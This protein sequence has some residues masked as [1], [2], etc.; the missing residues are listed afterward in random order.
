MSWLQGFGEFLWLSFLLLSPML[1]LGLFLSGLFHVFISREAV[2]RW[3]RDESLNSVSTSALIGVP[4]PLCSCS[5]VPVVA[6]MRRKGAS[7]SACI[8]F[9][10]TAP[11]TGADS[12]LV[13]NAFFGWIPAIF[14][15]FVSYVTAVV[16]G[17]VCIGLIREDQPAPTTTEAHEHEHEHGEDHSCGHDHEHDAHEKLVP[18]ED[19]CYIPLPALKDLAIERMRELGTTVAS[20]R[21]ISWLK[22]AFYLERLDREA[23]ER[24]QTP[25][26]SSAASKYPH[27]PNFKTIV[28]HIFRY[29]FVE[30]AD[31][32]LFALLVGIALG[33]V[34]YLA[35]PTD[36]LDNEYA[37]WFSYPIMVIVG[38][39]LYICASAS[40]P[41]AA[42]LVAKGFSPGAALIFLMTGPA[43]NTGTVAIIVSQF[44]AKF[45]TIYVSSVIVVTVVIG[46]LLDVVLLASGFEIVVNL[47]KSEST[48]IAF[49]QIVCAAILF[50]LIVW[51]FRAGALKSGWDDLWLNVRPVFEPVGRGLKRLAGGRDLLHALSFRAP[52]VWIFLFAFALI[53][54]SSGLTT[55]PPGH[56]GYGRIFGAV[57]WQD[58]QP[59]LHYLGPPPMV[60]VD[61]WPIKQVK[62]VSIA[63]DTE[64]VTGDLNLVRLD[65]ALQYRV[66][67][68][69]VYHYRM[70]NAAHILAD[71]AREALRVFVGARSLESLLNIERAKLESY[72]LQYLKESKQSEL[73]DSIDM[74]KASLLSIGPTGE[75]IKA[76]REV[77]SAQEDR[78]RIIVNGQRLLVT[79]TP[80]AHGN[81]Q[82]ELKVAEGQAF[83]TVTKAR[84]EADALKR[85]SN[86][87][88]GSRDVLEYMLWREK[89]ETA[90][91][92]RSK[93]IVPNA[94]SLKK[95]AL[96]KA[97]PGTNAQSSS[98]HTEN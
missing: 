51:R 49:T 95:V 82:Y 72:V 41:I 13:T 87:L 47:A 10:I 69:Y 3:F 14:R 30:I 28:R 68:P 80:R 26:P 35:I 33:G 45:A 92:G 17:I 2:L 79:V 20:W 46:I 6:E 52:P 16:A 21:I 75:T 78:E 94:E 65:T 70:N 54:A 85:I 1:L 90:L 15:P 86:S 77:S 31:D 22:P 61:K 19:D 59:G 63:S 97:Q 27:L 60:Q 53:Y 66:A 8:S 43:T 64:F 58:L 4:M 7:R 36:L 24:A 81:A 89:L 56:V 9:L 84:A 91:S 98:H 44:G 62:T 37:R 67:N 76:F 29:G 38:V 74:I 25:D 96:W 18:E 23:A 11:E 34:I 88:D 40:T 93:V 57:V 71:V 39:P 55:I 83:Q 5:V 48:A 32:I 12:I 50:G 73:M 42:A